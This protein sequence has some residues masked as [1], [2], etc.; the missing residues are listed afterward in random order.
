MFKVSSL[1]ND[2]TLAST[3]TFT[4]VP[5]NVKNIVNTGYGQYDSEHKVITFEGIFR[6]H[7]L[8][9]F[10]SNLCFSSFHHDKHKLGGISL[11]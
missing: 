7:C 2:I 3:T 10:K 1:P 9:G 6:D 4:G 5:V 11:Q 8:L